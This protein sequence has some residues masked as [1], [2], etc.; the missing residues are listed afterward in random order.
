MQK[1]EWKGQHAERGM[2][3]ECKRSNGRD[4]NDDTLYTLQFSIHK[5]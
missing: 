2:E 3:R 5:P 1:G 4:I